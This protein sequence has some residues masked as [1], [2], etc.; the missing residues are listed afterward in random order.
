MGKKFKAR[1]NSFPTP[2]TNI[3]NIF[4]AVTN[5]NL[6]EKKSFQYLAGEGKHLELLIALDQ[7]I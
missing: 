5:I 7:L 2:P 6:R 4:I 3:S 1:E